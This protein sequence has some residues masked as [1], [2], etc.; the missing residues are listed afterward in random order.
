MLPLWGSGGSGACLVWVGGL[1]SLCFYV[2]FFAVV[3][4]CMK[5]HT[6]W[7][8]MRENHTFLISFKITGFFAFSRVFEGVGG[9][10]IV[11]FHV[12]LKGSAD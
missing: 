4:K 7:R 9:L 2:F 10:I 12:F 8:E 11:H 6:F 3:Q 1:I 5:I